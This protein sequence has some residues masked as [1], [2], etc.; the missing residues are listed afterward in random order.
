M[1]AILEAC[2]RLGENPLSGK[3]RKELRPTLRS[4]AVSPYMVFYRIVG[5]RVQISR[6]L[7]QRQDAARIFRKRS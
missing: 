1:K 4:L 2:D 3:P 5:G 6:I 7:H